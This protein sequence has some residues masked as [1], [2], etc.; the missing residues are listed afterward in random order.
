MYYNTK[1]NAEVNENGDAL[2]TVSVNGTVYN[3]TFNI[4]EHIPP[5]IRKDLHDSL[6]YSVLAMRDYY[7]H[8]YRTRQI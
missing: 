5:Q 2:F 6:Y 1:I 4:C 3:Y 8:L 7:L